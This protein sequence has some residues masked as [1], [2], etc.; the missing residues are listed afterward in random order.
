MLSRTSALLSLAL[1]GSA[2]HAQQVPPFEL[3]LDRVEMNRKG[4]FASSKTYFIPTVYVRIS[5]RN[6][7]AAKNEGAQTKARIFIEGLDKA[8]LQGLAR[9]VYDDLVTKVRGAGFTVLT[10]EDLK[11]DVAGLD[12]IKVNPKFGFPMKSTGLSRP[13]DFAIATPS[14]EQAFDW[15]ITGPLWPYKA[16]AKEKNVVVLVPD[17]F[18]D[19]PEVFSKKDGD[20]WGKSIEIKTLPTMKLHWA[21]V[22][23]LSPKAG[24]CDIRVKEHGK[25]LVA[26]VAGTIKKVTEEKDLGEWTQTLSDFSFVIDPVAVSNG[27]LAVGYAI[28]DLT[29]KTIRKAH[30]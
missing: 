13:V 18:F 3:N 17:I 4:D 20:I 28:N 1:L 16:I 27:I 24:T 30:D 12:R 19:L 5:A 26:P 7:T 6:V 29:V 22:Q 25:R 10:Y 2:A 14:D 11:A 23:G 21:I 9:K 15:G 8:M